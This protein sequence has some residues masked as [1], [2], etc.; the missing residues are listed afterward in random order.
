MLYTSHLR[1]DREMVVAY[2]CAASVFRVGPVLRQIR[3]LEGVL[4]VTAH[5]FSRVTFPHDW[6]LEEIGKRIDTSPVLLA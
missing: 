4:Q 6:V 2:C 5:V 3:S 1:I